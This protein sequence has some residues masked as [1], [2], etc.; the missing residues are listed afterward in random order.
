MTRNEVD[1]IIRK[2]RDESWEIAPR[3]IVSQSPDGW[4]HIQ[5]WAETTDLELSPE[6]PIVQISE[7]VLDR[8]AK[9]RSA[10][11]RVRPELENFAEATGKKF[12]QSYVRFSFI[13][14]PGEWQYPAPDD[15]AS[16]T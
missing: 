5:C 6:K 2:I 16:A 9:G 8:M 10:F 12:I 1:Q 13:D 7:T 15:K 3:F 14:K 4:F 11:I